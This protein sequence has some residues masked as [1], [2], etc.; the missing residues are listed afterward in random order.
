MLTQE[1][2]EILLFIGRQP[3]TEQALPARLHS[4]A[5]ETTDWEIPWRTSEPATCF[6]QR[7]LSPKSKSVAYAQKSSIPNATQSLKSAKK[8][9]FCVVIRLKT[10][11]NKKNMQP[12]TSYQDKNVVLDTPDK[13]LRLNRPIFPHTVEI[14]YLFGIPAPLPLINAQGYR[15]AHDACRIP[16]YSYA[17]QPLKFFRRYGGLGCLNFYDKYT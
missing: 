11:Q 4:A 16:A 9:C 7:K 5:C 13:I 8:S 14:L 1:M 15:H 10:S 3:V 6:M 17:W 12:F 2:V